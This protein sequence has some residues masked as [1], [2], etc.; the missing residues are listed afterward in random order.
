[1]GDQFKAIDQVKATLID[2]GFKFGPKVL[3]AVTFLLIGLFVGHWIGRLTDR[4]LRKVHIEAPVRAL[5]VRTARV[6]VVGL[7]LLMAVQNLG[8]EL[9]PLLAGL[10]V[11]GAGVALAM[12]GV[13]GNLVAGLTVIFTNPFRI[14]EYISIAGEEGRVVDISL[15]NTVLA[16][17]DL[18]RVVI[19]NRKV[20][21][22][23]LHNY[24]R[25]RQLEVIV[26]VAADTNLNITLSA[27]RSVVEESRLVLQDP[28]P[29]IGI[30]AV[31]GPAIEIAVKPW[32]NVADYVPAGSEIRKAIVE[33]FRDQHVAGP[34]PR[35]DIR[36]I[37]GPA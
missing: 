3:V 35:Q 22:E 36:L 18:S 17:S 7:F 24:G 19:P 5:L 26:S 14:G 20:V 16:H 10:G 29:V 28:A 1:M 12:Q 21:G 37:G 15:F 33:K 32:V 31:T 34:V 25:I 13:L 8:I 30:N 11:A 23:I 6:I 4:G 9:L 2:L 27:L